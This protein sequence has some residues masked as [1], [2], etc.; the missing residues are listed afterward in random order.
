MTEHNGGFF[1]SVIEDRDQAR[2]LLERLIN[3]ARPEAVYSEPLQIGEHKVMTA[4]EVMV[5]LGMGYGGGQGP[6]EEGEEMGIGVG[7]G[8]GGHS[9]ARPVAIIDIGPE[10]VKIEPVIDPTKIVMAFFAALGSLFLMT[11]VL[12]HR[13]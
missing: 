2:E 4:S 8:G 1:S 5:G 12:R 11:T 7:G 6:V 3:I 10:G 9:K 13:R